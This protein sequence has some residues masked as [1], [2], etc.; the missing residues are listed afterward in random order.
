MR[1]DEWCCLAFVHLQT[2]LQ[3]HGFG[4]GLL[5]CNLSAS[6]SPTA[7]S[8]DTFDTMPYPG[9]KDLDALQLPNVK[10]FIVD[11]TKDDS[12]AA[13]KAF[14]KNECSE[15]SGR[16]LFVI[17][18]IAGILRGFISEFNSIEDWRAVFEV[19]VFGVWRATTALQP[20]LRRTA[21]KYPY[22]AGYAKARVITITSVAAELVFPA[23]S[24]YNSSKHAAAGLMSTLRLELANFGIAVVQVQ[25]WFAKSALFDVLNAREAE[26]IKQ[27]VSADALADYGGEDVLKAAGDKEVLVKAVPMLQPADVAKTMI[28]QALLPSNPAPHVVVGTLGKVMLALRRLLPYETSDKLLNLKA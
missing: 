22:S 1:R 5:T 7:R 20:L 6:H 25:P 10:T 21:K 2:R 19:N 13:M 28:E 11:V 4:V 8:F 17:W 26:K 18:N 23:G 15:A 16:N 9:Q 14:M 24:I 3:K 27:R 12:V